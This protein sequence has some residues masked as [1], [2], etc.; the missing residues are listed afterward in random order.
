MPSKTYRTHRA[1]AAKQSN[2]PGEIYKGGKR[3]AVVAQ[4]IKN[5]HVIK[6]MRT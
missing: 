4:S 6:G 3:G 2:L 1:H 5:A